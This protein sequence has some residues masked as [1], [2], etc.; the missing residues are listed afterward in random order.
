MLAA[1]VE[2]EPR[3]ALDDHRKPKRVEALLQRR[4]APAQ[5]GRE[6]VEVVDVERERE[7]SVAELRED[8]RRVLEPVVGEP[9]RR[10]SDPESTRA[11]GH[12]T[13]RR[14]SVFLGRGLPDP[15]G[16][17]ADGWPSV[18]PIAQQSWALQRCTA[19][20]IQKP[21]AAFPPPQVNGV[22]Q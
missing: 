10:V 14:P 9:A 1:R 3:A 17:V 12:G 18:L 19:A 5:V 4:R 22:A 13:M 6:R 20:A 8:L 15:P 7:R 11:R 2:Q 16:L 21:A